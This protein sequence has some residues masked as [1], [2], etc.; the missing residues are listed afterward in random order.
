MAMAY[1]HNKTNVPISVVNNIIK[2]HDTIYIDLPDTFK[3]NSNNL[4]VSY[5]GFEKPV[6][7]V[8]V[9]RD[10]RTVAQK[11]SRKQTNKNKTES[12]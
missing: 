2:P 6:E 9:E 11:R 7:Y 1:V 4:S 12:E 3:Y 5:S 8:A 10:T